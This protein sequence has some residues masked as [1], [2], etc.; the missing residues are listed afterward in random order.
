MNGNLVAALTDVPQT[1]N[2]YESNNLHI[3]TVMGPIY[4]P[5]ID[6]AGGDSNH[7][8]QFRPCLA[9]SVG[10]GPKPLT[11]A[12]LLSDGVTFSPGD[13]FDVHSVVDNLGRVKKQPPT[14]FREQILHDLI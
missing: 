6:I 9:R 7:N 5:L 12:F 13:A 3:H 10:P 14:S 2:P 8:I 11:Y 4:E 1:L